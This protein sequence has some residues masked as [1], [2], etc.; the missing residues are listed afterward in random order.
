MS[1]R[2]RAG[3]AQRGGRL[4]GWADGGRGG[5]LV[6]GRRDCAGGCARLQAELRAEDFHVQGGLS[7]RS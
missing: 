3:A 7:L 2:D 1:E 5:V 6:D 4:R